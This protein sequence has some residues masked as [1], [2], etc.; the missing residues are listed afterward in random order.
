MLS[1]IQGDDFLRDDGIVVATSYYVVVLAPVSLLSNLFRV[2]NKVERLLR[3]IVKGPLRL[4]KEVQVN[5]NRQ[6]EMP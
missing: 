2:G 4:D 5:V 3:G 1:V 6:Q